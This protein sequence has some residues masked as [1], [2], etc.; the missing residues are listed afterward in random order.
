M[1]IGPPPAQGIPAR[2]A[3]PEPTPL[4]VLAGIPPAKEV[5]SSTLEA[6]IRDA[7]SRTREL[8]D[9][10]TD[11]QLM[12]PRLR[13]VNPPGWEVGHVAWFHEHFILQRAYGEAPL[14]PAGW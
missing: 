9:D 8:I 3:P 13:T 10:L 5:E 2:P 12:G 6:Y 11:A 4:A 1:S 7:R 14:L